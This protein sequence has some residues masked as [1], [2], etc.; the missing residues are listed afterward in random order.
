MSLLKYSFV[1]LQPIGQTFGGE[2]E[3]WGGQG[4]RAWKDVCP[5]LTVVYILKQTVAPDELYSLSEDRWIHVPSCFQSPALVFLP[6]KKKK[7]K[8]KKK[9]EKKPGQ[10]SQATLVSV[11]FLLTIWKKNGARPVGFCIGIAFRWPSELLYKNK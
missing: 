9:K 7:K 6:E 3:V 8:K 2:V 5:P 4:V 10:H 11:R 1:G